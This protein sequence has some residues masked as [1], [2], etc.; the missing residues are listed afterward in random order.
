M[1][2]SAHWS[3]MRSS[4]TSTPDCLR[5]VAVLMESQSWFC[6]K[7]RMG[8]SGC[9]GG[10]GWDPLAAQL[11]QDGGVVEFAVACSHGGAHQRRMRLGQRQTLPR[12]L[13][14]AEHEVDVLQVLADARLRREVFV[15]HH[16]ALGQ[17]G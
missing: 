16:R 9:V 8:I 3:M 1:P 2:R 12:A 13:A 11:A 5:T 14:V 15:H 6:E 10:G 7:S 4:G 17:C